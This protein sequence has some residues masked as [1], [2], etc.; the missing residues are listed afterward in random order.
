MGALD[1]P[2]LVHIADLIPMQPDGSQPL[3]AGW[4][5]KKWRAVNPKERRRLTMDTFAHWRDRCEGVFARRTG[6]QYIGTF[7]IVVDCDVKH[8]IDGIREWHKF[9]ALHNSPASEFVVVTPS[10]GKHFYYEAPEWVAEPETTFRNWVGVL[11]GVD[12]RAQ[13]G[14]ALCPENIRILEETDAGTEIP[15]NL[16]GQAWKA[17]G[18][19]L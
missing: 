5:G 3:T 8:G 9:L 10:G 19:D 12:I 6:I 11:P 15:A 1:H 14:L 13:D 7:L 2:Y 18:A 17:R 16:K 4:Y